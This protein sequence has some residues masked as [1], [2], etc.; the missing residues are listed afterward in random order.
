MKEIW[1]DIIG[2]ENLYQVSNFGRIKSLARKAEK[3]LKAK[4]DKDYYRIGLFKNKKQKFYA[5]HRLVAQ[6][7]ISNPNNYSCVNHKDENKL[8]NFVDNLEWCSIIY[9]NNYGNR[10]LKSSKSKER[11]VEQYDLKDNFIKLWNSQKEAISTLKISNHITDVCNGR[12]KKCGGY[13][14]KFEEVK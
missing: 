12:R 1:K 3:I 4:I 10:T 2:Y 14:W 11:K 5:I 8:N 7:F 9:N 13:K 6:A